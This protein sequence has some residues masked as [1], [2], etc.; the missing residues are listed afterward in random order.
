MFIPGLFPFKWKEVQDRTM[1]GTFLLLGGAITMTAA[2]TKSGLA[3]WLAEEIHGL[4][5]GHSWW[6]VLLI[7]MVG[8]HIMRIGMLS[9]VAAVAMLAPILFELGKQLG[10]HPVAFT[11][12]VADTDTFAYLL[13]TQVTAAVIAY[14]TNTFS[15]TDYFKVGWVCVLI[16]IAY[17]ILIMAPW[18]ALLGLP[19]WD[20][21]APW[22][23]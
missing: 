1:W 13:P 11:M 7:L 10:L 20:P 12:L 6:M 2:M 21:S 16:A 9:N 3:A 8:T 18:Y 4:V 23:F 22:P 15:T 5:T 17:G 14:S 19:V